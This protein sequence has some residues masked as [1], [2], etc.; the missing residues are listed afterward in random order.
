MVL[1]AIGRGKEKMS[2]WKFPPSSKEQKKI[3]G[4]STNQLIY[5]V[6]PEN[7]EAS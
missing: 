4:C 2:L 5:P 6:G 3:I 7:R 1:F